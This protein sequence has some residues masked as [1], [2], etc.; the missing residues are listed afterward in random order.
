V[1]AV[2]RRLKE[3]LGFKTET[4]QAFHFTY[5]TVF[6]NGLTEHEFDHVFTGIYDGPVNFN[7]EE[8]M[9]IRYVGMKELFEELSSGPERFTSWFHI[10]FPFIQDWYQKNFETLTPGKK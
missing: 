9:A 1:A 2:S 7:Q 10:A 6:R 8:V 4:R 5:R 3:E